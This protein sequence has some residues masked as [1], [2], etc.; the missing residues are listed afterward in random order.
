MYLWKE[1]WCVGFNK[2]EKLE[3]PELGS[4]KFHAIVSICASEIENG[5]TPPKHPLSAII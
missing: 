1:N 4:P 2:F 5:M 3:L